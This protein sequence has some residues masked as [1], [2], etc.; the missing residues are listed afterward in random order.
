MA[1][2]KPTS[3]DKIAVTVDGKRTLFKIGDHLKFSEKD[4]M[5]VVT[6]ISID[7]DG[8]IAYLL[9]YLHDDVL[10]SQWMTENDFRMMC[11]LD[12]A[13]SVIGFE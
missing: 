5:R 6:K 12:Q 8:C 7:S 1:R 13:P 11:I 9:T 4:V 10:T 2:A 3:K